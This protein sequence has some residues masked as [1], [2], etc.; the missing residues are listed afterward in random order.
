VM[1]EDLAKAMFLRANYLL[2]KLLD[3][4]GRPWESFQ[5]PADSLRFS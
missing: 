3:H 1:P 5:L 4:R 2:E